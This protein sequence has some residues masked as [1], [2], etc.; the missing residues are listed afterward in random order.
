M[1][2][3]LNYAPP[4]LSESQLEILRRRVCDAADR[5]ADEQIL[6][7]ADSLHDTLRARRQMRGRVHQRVEDRLCHEGGQAFP[8]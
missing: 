6:G 7:L 4:R 8:F 2:Q 5:M 1:G 3:S